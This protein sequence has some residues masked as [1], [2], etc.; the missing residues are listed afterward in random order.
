MLSTRT[1][2]VLATL[3]IL[4]GIS[5]AQTV[6]PSAQDEHFAREAASG[7]MLEV[8]LGEYASFN[9]ASDAVKKFA[10][11]MVGDHTEANNKLKTVASEKAI[12][13]PKV[14]NEEDQK[15]LDRLERLKGADFDKAYVE[16]MVEDHLQ[17]IH[18]FEKEINDGTDPTVKAFAEATLPTLKPHLEMAQALQGK[19]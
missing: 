18:A 3:F 9:A 1:I 5:M 15:V 14:L 6:Q 10:E 13:L 16:Q 17:D 7:G 19:V 2:C 11:K 4:S 8:R 12:E